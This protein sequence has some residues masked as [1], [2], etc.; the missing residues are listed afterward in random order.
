MLPNRAKSTW[1]TLSG[2]HAPEVLACLRPLSSDEDLV[3]GAGIDALECLR[4]AGDLD[5]FELAGCPGAPTETVG[6][7][8]VDDV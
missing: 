3:R 8:D 1:W 4:P 7:E 6:G 2:R 5:R